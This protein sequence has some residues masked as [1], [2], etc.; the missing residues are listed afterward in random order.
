MPIGIFIYE[1]DKSFGPNILIDYYLTDDKITSEILTKLN[2]KHINKKLKEAITKKKEIRYYSR[3]LQSKLLDK[4]NLFLGFILREEEDLLS[5]KS[6]FDNIKDQVI[7][8]FNIEDKKKMQKYLKDLLNSILNLIEKLKEPK[9]IKETINEKTKKMLD[10][11]KLQEAREL[12]DLG[13]SI[14]GE[15]SVL[16]READNLLKEG[17]YKK[18]KKRFLKAAEQAELIQED[19]IVLFLRKKSEKV[20]NFPDLI[21][22]REII[23][24]ELKKHFMDSNKNQFRPYELLTK[25]IERLIEISNNFDENEI[26]DFLNNLLNE[27]KK[28]VDLSKKLSDL[29]IKIVGELNKI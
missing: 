27:I 26:Y 11:G 13:E 10:E 19:E 15:L 12:I 24:K 17:E 18:A 25:P 29:D 9:I 4:K 23:Q 22:E 1:I 8:N 14:P 3:K 16:V 21:K 20:G 7:E 2:E 6:V 28:G 5:L